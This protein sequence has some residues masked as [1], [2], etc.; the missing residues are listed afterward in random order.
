MQRKIGI[1]TD[2]LRGETDEL[3]VLSMAH[4]IGFECF[5]TSAFTL[6]EVAAL[7]NR[8]DALGMD[9]PFLHAPYRGI[10]AMWLEG[11][12][13]LPLYEGMVTA[14]DSAAACGVSA[15]I[16]HVSSG[17]QAPP[18]CDL[19]LS[20]YDAL[21]AHAE[22]KGVTLAFENLRMVGN[23]ACLMDRY[24]NRD[25]VRFCFDCGHEHAYTKTV[26]WPDIFTDKM[27]ATHIHDNPGRDFYD[28]ES[29]PDLHWLPFDGTYNYHSMMRRLDAYGYAG[30]LVLE[31]FRSMRED[32]M[33]LSD[34]AFLETAYE[35]IKRI[36]TL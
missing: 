7:K 6:P 5:T 1:N 4:E 32:Y 15:V 36:S 9:F 35:R 22:E 10:N 11:D 31:V 19:G 28:K 13:H 25:A 23:L 8:A 16:T 30:P 24:A 34:K 29:N 27:V 18:V 21:V 33:A 20:R 3:T 2:C 14:I 26:S 12:G 17:W